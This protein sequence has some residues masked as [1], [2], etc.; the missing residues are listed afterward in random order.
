ML[1]EVRLLGSHNSRRLRKTS[2]RGALL[3]K[4][5]LISS[6]LEGLVTEP[7]S[8]LGDVGEPTVRPGSDDEGP[9]D[10]PSEL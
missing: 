8:I 6:P 9:V 1:E 2:T 4:D 3:P 7:C 5:R 10:S